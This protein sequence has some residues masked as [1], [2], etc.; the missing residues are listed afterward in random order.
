[1]YYIYVVA[2]LSNEILSVQ[3]IS[4]MEKS[5]KITTCDGFNIQNNIHNPME[6]NHT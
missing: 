6:F 4:E 1:M 2:D 3:T 5:G